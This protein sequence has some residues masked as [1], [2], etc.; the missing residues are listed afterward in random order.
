MRLYYVGSSYLMDDV[1]LVPGADL[2]EGY[3]IALL[4]NTYQNSEPLA[5]LLESVEIYGP[6]LGFKYKTEPRSI[7]SLFL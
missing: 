7:A 6:N 1:L 2:S 3:V 4:D 5:S